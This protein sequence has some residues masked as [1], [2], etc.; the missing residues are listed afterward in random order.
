MSTRYERP[1]FEDRYFPK[2]VLR[3]EMPPSGITRTSHLR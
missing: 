3:K 1:A 2:G